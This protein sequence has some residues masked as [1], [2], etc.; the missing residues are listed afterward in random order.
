M[1][2][3]GQNDNTWGYYYPSQ[4]PTA[5]T[6]RI[7]DRS[8]LKLRDVNISYN[9][10]SRWASKIKAQNIVGV[11]GKKYFT[12]DSVGNQFIDPEGTNLGNDLASQLGEFASAP[13]SFYNGVLLRVN[14]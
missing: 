4:N 13:I 9:L 1:L 8:F 6:N 7:I 11:F 14:F 5:Y 2:W 10:S 12:V 3:S